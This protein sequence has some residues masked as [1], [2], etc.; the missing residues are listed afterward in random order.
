VKKVPNTSINFL[1]RA[2]VAARK[3]LLAL[4]KF[5]PEAR[6][7]AEAAL[8]DPYVEKFHL[9][10]AEST[11]DKV[12]RMPIAD[13]TKMKVADYRN[14]IYS[15]I[16][17]RKKMAMEDHAIECGEARTG[18]KQSNMGSKQSSMF[19][20]TGMMRNSKSTL[21]SARSPGFGRRSLSSSRLRSSRS[22]L[23][24]AR[25]S[26]RSVRSPPPVPWTHEGGSV[27][28]PTTPR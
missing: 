18:S 4:L 24:S 26:A 10:E 28:P 20:S 2:P 16:T 27:A 13:T 17:Q 11:C 1:V 15:M 22:T 25:E 23:G 7:R 3:L 14:Q 21:G 12:I 19:R 5:N 6:P 9:Q 8:E